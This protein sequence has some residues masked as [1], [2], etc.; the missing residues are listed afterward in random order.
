MAAT[1]ATIV[2]ESAQGV[3]TITLNRPDALNALNAD[4][5]VELA[6]ALR[7]GQRDDA[8]RCLLLTG[9]GRAFCAGLDLRET[10]GTPSAPAQLD[11]GELLRERLNPLIL[12]M[13]TMEKPI[14]AAVNGVAAGGGAGL[15]LAADLRVFAR[16]AALR[17]AFPQVGLVP[18]CGT[19]LTLVQIAG[20]G[21]ASELCLLDETVAAERCLALGLATRVVDDADLPA[22]A[23]EIAVKLA[24][25]PRLALALTKRALTRAW[26]ATLDEQL[27]YEALLQSTA[28][29][30]S[31]HQEG[32]AAFL[33]KRPPRFNPPS[34]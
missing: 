29:R 24:A 11:L 10:R 17:M 4:M 2:T 34:P 8:I 26:H 12:R 23:R 25:G 22:A 32:V 28:G 6:A 30:G 20:L 7:A 1:F 14:V 33:N 19:T 31:E 16:S 27:E 21:R 3:L 13:R 15:A 18:D 9:R 5:C